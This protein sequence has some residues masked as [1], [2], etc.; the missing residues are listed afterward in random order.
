MTKEYR[1][2]RHVEISLSRL[3]IV[4]ILAATTCVLL[5]AGLAGQVSK[6]GFGHVSAY[7]LIRL[8]DLDAEENVPTFFS[9][10]LLLLAALLLAL[11][12][13]LKRASSDTYSRHWATL[14]LILLYMSVDE[15]S[16]IHEMFIKP[17]PTA[18]CPPP[19]SF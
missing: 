17:P 15:F 13:V 11:I 5:V 3:T 16:G 6:Y 7:G 1:M 18:R 8:F 9:A 19:A 12:T 14:S 10:L 2:P 4:R